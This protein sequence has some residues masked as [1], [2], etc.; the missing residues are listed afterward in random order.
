MIHMPFHRPNKAIFLSL[1]GA[2]TV[3]YNEEYDRALM[4]INQYLTE[5]P[6]MVCQEPGDMLYLY[7]AMS[8][9]LV[10]V[11]LFKEDEN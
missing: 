10:S 2:K 1:R 7:L 11:A 9:A 5:P 8:R 3:G 4:V 6:I